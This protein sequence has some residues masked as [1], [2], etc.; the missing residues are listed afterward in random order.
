MLESKSDLNVSG[1]KKRKVDQQELKRNSNPELNT[2]RFPPSYLKADSGFDENVQVPLEFHE[3]K[4]SSSKKQEDINV[5]EEETAD[6][7][8]N[9]QEMPLEFINDKEVELMN[10]DKNQ[11]SIKLTTLIANVQQKDEP[12]YNEIMRLT[13]NLCPNSPERQTSR[14]TAELCTISSPSVASDIG[15]TDINDCL[16]SVSVGSRNYQNVN[17]PNIEI[18]N[19]FLAIHGN[20]YNFEHEFRLNSEKPDTNIHN[21]VVDECENNEVVYQTINN[22][23]NCSSDFQMLYRSN[24]YPKITANPITQCFDPSLLKNLNSCTVKP[25]SMLLCERRSSKCGIINENVDC[26]YISI[27][28]CLV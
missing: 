22:E 18:S 9:L 2:D 7:S 4:Y 16:Q 15:I 1:N 24:S 19:N 6:S 27:I 17:N 3:P 11:Q 25:S 8:Q 28:Q 14:V 5:T 26:Y 21:N 23:L 12:D 10:S 13:E 20:V